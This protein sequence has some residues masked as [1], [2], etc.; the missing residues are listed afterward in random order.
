MEMDAPDEGIANLSRIRHNQNSIDPKDSRADLGSNCAQSDIH[1][2][3]SQEDHADKFFYILT[4][5]EYSNLTRALNSYIA[6]WQ[7]VQ[8]ETQQRVNVEANRVSPDIP[9]ITTPNTDCYGE[10]QQRRAA[11]TQL[12]EEWQKRGGGQ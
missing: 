10:Q 3:S 5:D 7:S 9:D 6:F 4:H 2:S 8:G 12:L 11:H 1:R